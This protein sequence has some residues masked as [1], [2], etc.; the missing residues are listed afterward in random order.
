MRSHAV[1]RCSG[2]EGAA[3]GDKDDKD[4]CQPPMKTVGLWGWGGGCHGAEWTGVQL[5]PR[6]AQPRSVQMQKTDVY[7]SR[8]IC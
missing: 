2:L 6:P 7:L 4:R 3:Y 5:L 1:Q 8:I